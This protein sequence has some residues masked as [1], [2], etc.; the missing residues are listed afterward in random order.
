M[1]KYQN[2]YRIPSAR[3]PW[4]DYSSNAAYFVTICTWHRIHFFGEIVETQNIA[5]LIASPIGIIAETCWHEI[6][7]H[8]PFVELGAFT[9]MPN[10]V[11]GIVIIN[12]NIDPIVET[13]NIASLHAPKTKNHFGPQ[14]QNLGSIIRGYKIGVTNQSKTLCPEFRWQA[15]FHDHIIRND[16]EFQRIND[17]IEQNP[18]N[19]ENDK[20]F[21]NDLEP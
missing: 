13:Q 21:K 17:Y 7:N 4:W 12:K 8:F 15:R 20:F 16:A 18:A 3:A 10:H 2:K 9:V 14:S 11:H 5:S 19:W 6:P 1:E